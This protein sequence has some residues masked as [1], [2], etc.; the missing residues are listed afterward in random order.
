MSYKLYYS[1]GACSMAVH[2]ILNEIN[3]PFELINANQPGTKTRSAEFLKVNPSG[4]VPVMEIDGTVVKEG[5]AL[6]T[7]L[8]DTHK[9]PLL[10]QEG[11]ARAKALEALMFC[12]A[13]LH[14]NYSRAF[15][16]TKQSDPAIKEQLLKAAC[17]GINKLWAETDAKLAKQKYLAGDQITAGDI[18]MTVI[19]GW[20]PAFGNAIQIP[21]NVQRVIDEVHARP[22]F[23]KAKQAE[24][25][26]AKA[27]A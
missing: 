24:S 22:A 20:S 25:A 6:I 8:C 7:Y 18:L 5:G 15:G 17:E 2:V 12:N 13:T 11:L 27:A 26:P 3:Q 1:A 10:P 19:A 9:S 4:A 14:P 23:Q 21:S 16:A